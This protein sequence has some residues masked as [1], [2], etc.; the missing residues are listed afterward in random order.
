V[1]LATAFAAIDIQRTPGAPVSVSSGSGDG[2][3]YPAAIDHWHAGPVKATGSPLG[4]VARL[5]PRDLFASIT[6]E[7][8]SISPVR[9]SW[10]T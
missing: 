10:P 1:A 6:T 7:Q 5:P 3:P 9:E 4:E 8:A 2:C